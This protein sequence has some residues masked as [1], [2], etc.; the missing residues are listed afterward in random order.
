M[1]GYDLSDI[2]GRTLEIVKTFPVQRPNPDF[3]SCIS[4]SEELGD[5]LN[6]CGS[7]ELLLH[8]WVFLRGVRALLEDSIFS[9]INLTAGIPSDK[10][11]VQDKCRPRVAGVMW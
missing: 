8:C 11:T 3:D 4:A 9:H 1:E 7:F 10:L 2:L 5:L 6:V